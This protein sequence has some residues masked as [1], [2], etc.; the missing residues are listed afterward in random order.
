MNIYV[1]VSTIPLQDGRFL[2]KFQFIETQGSSTT[3]IPYELG[4]ESVCDSEEE[5]FKHAEI[6]A[7]RQALIDYGEGTELF[8]KREH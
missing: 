7:R 1:S 3:F 4:I 8:I 6:H 5:A 2:P